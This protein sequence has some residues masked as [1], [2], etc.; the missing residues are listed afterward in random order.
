MKRT[1]YISLFILLFAQLSIAQSPTLLRVEGIARMTEVPEEVIVSIN[2]NVKDS[3]YQTCFNKSMQSLKELKAYF[4]KNGIDPKLIKSKN[5][6]VNEAFEY[7][8]NKRMKIGYV[9]DIALEIKAPFTQKFSNAL[10][11]S[12][13]HESMDINYNIGFG[14]SDEQKT[15]LRQKAIELAVTDARQKA[16]TIAKAAGLKLAGI[17]SINYGSQSA[18]F[19]QLDM[20]YKQEFNSVTGAARAN[21]FGV[22]DLNPKEQQIQKSISIEWSFTE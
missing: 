16:E 1:T 15:K 17:Q 21:N 11:T 19:R 14:F 2:L 10:L 8:H 12:L 13:D 6:A 3:L 7:R 5:V 20:V 18:S 9:A 4:K 22:V